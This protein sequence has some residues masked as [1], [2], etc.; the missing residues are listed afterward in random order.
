M[1]LACLCP[2]HQREKNKHGY[3]YANQYDTI[4]NRLS[5][6][7]NSFSLTYQNKVLDQITTRS[8]SGGLTVQG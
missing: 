3:A 4:G 1:K 2:V 7:R 6:T 8:W 5:E